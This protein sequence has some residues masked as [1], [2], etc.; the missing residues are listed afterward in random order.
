MYDFTSKT[1]SFSAELQS[2][3]SPNL[4]NEARVS[5]VRVRDQRTSGQPAPSIT[6][7]KVGNGTVNI[8]NEYSSMANGLNQD[9]YTLEDNF[10]WY[11]GND[12]LTF[13]TT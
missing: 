7:Y 5:Y 1:H 2:R 8:G 13:G 9:I 11:K 4:S 6:I 12:S 3:I 10:T